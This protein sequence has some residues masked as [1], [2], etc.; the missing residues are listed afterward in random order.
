MAMDGRA[1]ETHETGSV[2]RG[3]VVARRTRMYAA[4][5]GGHA[6]SNPGKNPAA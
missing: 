1:S 4:A 6:Q 5:A 3:E 2:Q